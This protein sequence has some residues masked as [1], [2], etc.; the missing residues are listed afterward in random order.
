MVVVGVEGVG[1]GVAEREEV[2]LRGD[3]P[4]TDTAKVRVSRHTIILR[5][6]II[7]S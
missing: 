2:R 7:V 3:W 5:G 6:F 4:K 1:V